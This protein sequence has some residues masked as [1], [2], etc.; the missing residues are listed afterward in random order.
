M[1][2]NLRFSTSKVDL[3]RIPKSG[4]C[5]YRASQVGHAI[6]FSVLPKFP[7]HRLSA[8]SI[9][10]HEMK[11]PFLHNLKVLCMAIILDMA[12][13]RAQAR[14]NVREN[15]EQEAHPQ[16]PQVPVDPLAEQ[17]T[18]EEFKAAFQVLDQAVTAQ[19]NR[20]WYP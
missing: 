3:I 2:R 14:R 20:E 18:N 5:I 19:A 16:A 11:C 15:A 7:P 10:Y 12:T 8:W 9:A 1:T 6:P 17:V 4:Y 13:R